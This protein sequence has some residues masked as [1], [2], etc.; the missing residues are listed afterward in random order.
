MLKSAVR[1][2][3]NV[4]FFKDRQIKRKI[5]FK[6]K[7]KRFVPSPFKANLTHSYSESFVIAMGT[8]NVL[9]G[10]YM[11]PLQSELLTFLL[12]Q[13]TKPV[14]FCNFFI[15]ATRVLIYLDHL[16]G[17]ISFASNH[18]SP[19]F[20]D[21]QPSEVCISL[22]SLV[23]EILGH[24]YHPQTTQSVNITHEFLK[25]FGRQLFGYQDS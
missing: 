9:N 15:F 20:R 17:T 8:R 6:I 13:S 12:H 1:Q 23:L 18:L 14:F 22:V 7:I 19:K 4:M 3:S 16:S 21:L 5:Q 25:G 11:R 10:I 24:F 2:L